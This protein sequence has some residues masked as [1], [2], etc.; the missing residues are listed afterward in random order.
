MSIKSSDPVITNTVFSG[1]KAGVAGAVYMATT[2]AP[3]FENC[4]FYNNT[5]Y[6]GG[7]VIPMGKGRY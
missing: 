7:W 3:V 5:V 1:N 2:S 6:T 4:Y